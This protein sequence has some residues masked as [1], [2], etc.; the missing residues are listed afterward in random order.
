MVEFSD[1]DF[2]MLPK[3]S[4][5]IELEARAGSPDQSM[6]RTL[7]VSAANASDTTLAY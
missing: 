7:I 6:D 3:E 1:N 2:E 4:K 5:E